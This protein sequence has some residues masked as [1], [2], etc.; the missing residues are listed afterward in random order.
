MA[1]TINGVVGKPSWNTGFPDGTR[2]RTCAENDTAEIE[3]VGAFNLLSQPSTGSQL[4]GKLA[5]LLPSPGAEKSWGVQNSTLSGEQCGIGI[6]RISCISVDS[7]GAADTTWDIDM[8]EVQRSLKQHP[9]ILKSS[10]ALTEIKLWEATPEALRVYSSKSGLEFRYYVVDENGEP[11]K[12][13]TVK[14]S[15]A[16]DYLKAL[17]AG[18]ETYNVYLPVVTKTTR[19]ISIL[20]EGSIPYS[21]V[22][23][24]N[25]PSTKPSGYSGSKHWFKSADKY[26]RANN[27]TWTRTEQWTYT[28]DTT[29]SWI[30]E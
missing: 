22:G 13:L 24:F 15:A 2:V 20:Q 29:H 10:N 8:Q 17:M 9:T 6:L 28:D 5:A 26:S 30:Y 25:E 3:I 12:L 11:G 18:I 7:F 4:S 1:T 16:I 27:G 19:Y 23:T 21:S 14:D